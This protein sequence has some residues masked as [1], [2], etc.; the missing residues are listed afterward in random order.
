MGLYASGS[1]FEDGIIDY[2]FFYAPGVHHFFTA[3]FDPDSYDCVRDEFLGPYRTRDQSA[4]RRNGA[5]VL[6][7]A[8]WA[9]IT[10]AALHKTFTL[11]PGTDRPQ[12]SHAG[13]RFSREGGTAN[14][15]QVCRS[16]TVDKAFADLRRHW[17]DKLVRLA[18]RYAGRRHELDGQ[19]LDPVPGRYLCDMVS[20]RV[21]HRSRRPN[22]PGLSGYR[23]GRD[24][25]RAYESA[26]GRAADCRAAAWPGLRRASPC[27]CLILRLI[28]PQAGW[29]RLHGDHSDG[30][31]ERRRSRHT[32]LSQD[33]KDVCSDDALW[34]VVT[35]CEFV[36]E[37]GD[38]DFFD[39]VVPFADSGE[40]TV[41]DHLKRAL[42]FSAR[43]CRSPRNL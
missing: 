9:A 7:V 14:P 17:Q 25:C 31:D 1:S 33:L 21:L 36:K 19:H 27:I 39:R 13:R 15:R 35:V 40:A 10:V 34:L 3:N 42:D 32:H 30:Y 22:R 38:D 11:E 6:G 23:A 24:E 43:A 29:R 12:H 26:T 41:Y 20:L 5:D 2:D 16:P 37:T 4:G 8:V 28:L 18:V